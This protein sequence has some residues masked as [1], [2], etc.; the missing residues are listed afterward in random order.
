MAKQL[1]FKEEARAKIK[2]G[3]EKL[4]RAVKVTLG[5]TGRN[6]ILEKSFGN[7]T[8]T[9]D[10]VTVAK[11]IELA[12]PFE[13]MGAKLVNEVASKTSEVAGDGT[14]TATILAEAVFKE[15]L[16]CL[17]AGVNPMAMK[18]GIDRAV[19]AVVEDLKNLS[20]E[21]S[22]KTEISQVGAISANNDKTIGDL[23]ADAMDKVGKDGVI[24]VEEGKGTET[25]LDLV[26][27]LQ[28][29]KGFISPYFVNSPE[30]MECILKDA[31]VLIHEKKISNLREF[32]PV[33]EKVAQTGKPLL[34]IAEDVEGEALAAL[35]INRIRGVLQI[36][37]VKAPGFGERRKAMLEDIAILTGGK[38]VSEEVGIKLENLQLGDLGHARTVKVDKD[39]TTVVEG[40]GE[41]QVIEQRIAQIKTQIEQSTSDYDKEKLN[42]RLAKLTG[43]VALIK[44]GAHTETEMKERKARVEDALHATRAA[45]E[46][47]IIPG[48]G[49]ALVRSIDKI[50]KLAEE[51]E[52]DESYGVRI[53]AKI[54]GEPLKHIAVNSGE[55]GNVVL[56]DVRGMETS[57]GFDASTHQF[58]DMFE[59]GVIDP[60]KV[61]RCALQNASSIAS[62]MLTT[63]TL[64]TDLKEEEEAVEGAVS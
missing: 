56:E 2:E 13:N 7:P 37:A 28:F 34:V 26:E 60:T 10:G 8:V 18:R 24:T 25:T 22:E 52:G 43:G 45:V 58:V 29:D 4:A 14:T 9:K 1:V 57:G 40:A 59:A 36:C 64:V 15:G 39:T 44:V 6:V 27:G 23:L 33:L 32:L 46:E 19:G 50:E 11:E 42:E 49:V 31:Y 63:E 51:V 61:T 62:L 55:D 41:I 38:V 17:A 47:G 21:V 53:I 3:V 5:P 54:L 35:V 16:K 20:R 30:T 48:G 12:D